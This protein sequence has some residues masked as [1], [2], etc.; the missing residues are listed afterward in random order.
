MNAHIIQGQAL[1]Q[2]FMLYFDSFSA[3]IQDPLGHFPVQPAVENL[4]YQGVGLVG[5]MTPRGV[6]QPLPFCDPVTPKAI[7]K[8]AMEISGLDEEFEGILQGDLELQASVLVCFLT[9]I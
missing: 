6:F 4:L 5:W 8:L 9:H 1:L 2:F 7:N 3:D